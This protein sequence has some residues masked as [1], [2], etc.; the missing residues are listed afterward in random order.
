MAD[1]LQSARDKLARGDSHRAIARREIRGFFNRHPHPTFKVKPE[2][3][4]D[5]LNVGDIWRAAIVV[6]QG[7]PD[8][9]ASF[10]ARFGDIV[11][12]Y[13]CVIDH[14]AWQLVRHGSSWPLPD[15]AAESAVQFPIYDTA[16]RFE[17]GLARRLPGADATAIDYI[18]ERYQFDAGGSPTN[19]AL[20]GL[21]K[22]SNNDKH[23]T[24]H[25]SLGVFKYLHTNAEFT[26]CL[27][28]MWGQP[29]GRPS[30]KQG[31]EVARFE[32]VVTGPNPKMKMKIAPTVQVVIED[33][34][35]MSEMIEGLRVEVREILN[36]PEIIAAV[37]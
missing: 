24:L 34:A 7:V 32:V 27:P 5:V 26:R 12:N 30:L 20:L 10:A 15:E 2:T 1:V 29:P 36:A 22:L 14:I 23:R 33:W 31:T 6:E 35:D 4:L 28:R 11:H 3:D 9:P 16:T 13:R 37:S 18:R 19:G 25:A 21:A 8:L 17:N